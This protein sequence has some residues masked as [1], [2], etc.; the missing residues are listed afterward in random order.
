M[1]AEQFHHQKR[2]GVVGCHEYANELKGP[3]PQH[4]KAAGNSRDS[5]KVRAHADT[6][7]RDGLGAPGTCLGPVRPCAE[8]GQDCP[9]AS[10]ASRILRRAAHLLAPGGFC[11]AITSVMRHRLLEVAFPLQCTISVYAAPGRQ[12]QSGVQCRCTHFDEQLV[13]PLPDPAKCDTAASI[14][15][16][17][18]RIG[19]EE[20]C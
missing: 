8:E 9:N 3:Q 19:E 20:R 4:V 2:D 12:G 10:C 13:R 15:D 6:K 7:H 18:F 1:R 16:I 14:E 5:R 11:A 17:P